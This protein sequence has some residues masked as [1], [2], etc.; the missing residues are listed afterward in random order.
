[1]H[2]HR[3][4]V[5]ARLPLAF[6]LSTYLIADWMA[7]GLAPPTPGYEWVRYGPD[8]L[9]VDPNTGQIADGAYSAFAEGDDTDAS[10]YG[11]APGPYQGMPPNQGPPGYA[12]QP[13]LAAGPQTLGNYANWVAAVY[14][15]NGQQVCYASTRALGSTPPVANRAAP[16][17]TVTE[18]LAGRDAVS[19]GGVPGN[20]GTTMYVD[21]AGLEFYPAA[22]NAYASDGA[23]AVAAFRSG[24]QAVVQSTS[25]Y[26]G[27]VTDTF[28]L[29]GFSA[30]YAAINAACPM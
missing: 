3:Y 16:V 15:E 14:Q 21:G 10:G 25:P 4:G 20:G 29:I 27:Q 12:G 6:I 8:I 23:S 7:Y 28:S 13:A 9:L 11:Q 1:M 26:N 30:A 5:G 17:L 22:G 24:N 2:Y 19:L 18:R